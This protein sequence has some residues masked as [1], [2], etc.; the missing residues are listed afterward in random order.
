MDDTV[1]VSKQI[2]NEVKKNLMEIIQDKYG[3]LVLLQ[4]LVPG[5]KRYFPQVTID[6]LQPVLV[7]SAED[8]TKLVSTSKKDPE[9]RRLE[10]WNTMQ[11][12]IIAMFKRFMYKIITNYQARDVLLETIIATTGKFPNYTHNNEG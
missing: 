5:N 1:L 7:P 2:L 3:R 4:L 10:L 12:D 11:K 8:P 9:I 6:L